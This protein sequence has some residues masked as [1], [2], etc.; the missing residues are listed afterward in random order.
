MP[1][2]LPPHFTFCHKSRVTLRVTSHFV[3]SLA[4]HLGSLRF[5]HFIHTHTHSLSL[6]LIFPSASCY[7][8]FS[9]SALAFSPS[10][11]PPASCQTLQLCVTPSSFASH[12]P[13]LRHTLGFTSSLVRLAHIFEAEASLT[14][15][16]DQATHKALSSP[17]STLVRHPPF[18]GLAAHQ[19]V[20]RMLQFTDTLDTFTSF[21]VNKYIDYHAFEIAF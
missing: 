20:L 15:L 7:F 13:A 2:T 19:H 11:T 6:S 9:I 10:V 5:C 21:Y 14:R 1:R 12:P 3:T 17:C 4:S 18:T 16:S 8:G